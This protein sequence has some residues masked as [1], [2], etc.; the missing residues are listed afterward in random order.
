M[1]RAAAGASMVSGVTAGHYD[2]DAQRERVFTLAL[3]AVRAR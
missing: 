3:D 2:D 1:A